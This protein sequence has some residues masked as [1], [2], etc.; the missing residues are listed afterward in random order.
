MP[1]H[2]GNLE[3]MHEP[4][5]AAAD[6]VG[7][8]EPRRQTLPDLA[9]L[10]LLTQ[11]ISRDPQ[12]RTPRAGLR[13]VASPS[14]YVAASSTSVPPARLTDTKRPSCPAVRLRPSPTKTAQTAQSAGVRAV[15]S[16]RA[17]TPGM[18]QPVGEADHSRSWRSS[19]SARP[20][21]VPPASQW[22]SS[23]SSSPRPADGP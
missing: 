1:S 5:C 22:C 6:A 19:W 10:D 12:V 4:S 2:K 23:S 15:R 18:L 21:P 8:H 13:H 7:T 17:A 16:R 9:L 11:R 3:R 20:A 14:S